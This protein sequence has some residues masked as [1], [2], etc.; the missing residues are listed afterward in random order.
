MTENQT[1]ILSLLLRKYNQEKTTSILGRYLDKRKALRLIKESLPLLIRPDESTCD[2]DDDA[3]PHRGDINPL[4]SV[5]LDEKIKSTCYVSR[6]FDEVFNPAEYFLRETTFDQ[7]RQD[8]AQNPNVFYNRVKIL[9]KIPTDRPSEL[10]LRINLD[11]LEGFQFPDDYGKVP[12]KVKFQFNDIEIVVDVVDNK[13]M[14]PFPVIFPVMPYMLVYFTLL[15][16][17]DEILAEDKPVYVLGGKCA[18]DVI[19]DTRGMNHMDFIHFPRE[20]T[21]QYAVYRGGCMAMI[22]YK[23]S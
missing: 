23:Q 17:N 15:G 11:I 7:L 18:L 21:K 9:H 1:D 10:F 12:K 20:G 5:L 2:C 16:E 6:R 14:C 22:E 19:P 4:V 8:F 13:A 3:C